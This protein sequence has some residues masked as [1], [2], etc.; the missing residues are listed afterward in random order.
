MATY[1]NLPVYRASYDLLV[2]LFRFTKDFS[3]EYKFTLGESIKKETVEMITA[4][5]RAN[6][7]MVERRERIQAARENVEV[8]R[9]F[10]RLL[11]D[12]NQVNVKKFVSLNE[13]LESVSKQLTAW[14]GPE[15]QSVYPIRKA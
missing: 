9:L 8:I 3:R 7:T 10:L 4:I 15:S 2:D 6:S 14:R 12:L 5:Y 11:K 1:D 13:K